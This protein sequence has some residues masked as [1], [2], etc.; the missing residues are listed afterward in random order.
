MTTHTAYCVPCD[1]ELDVV[2]E[3]GQTEVTADR[4]RCPVLGEACRPESCLLR[5]LS[6][7]RIR[8][9]LDF[10]PPS[11]GQPT[12][13]GFEEASRLVE[14]ARRRSLGREAGRLHRWWREASP[15][16]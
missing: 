12:S 2:L 4:V 13:R 3:E 5:P 1:I 7:A 15:G 6:P 10:L 11:L 14:L 16:R 9:H 8:A